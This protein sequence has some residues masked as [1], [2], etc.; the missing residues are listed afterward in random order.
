MGKNGNGIIKVKLH[1]LEEERNR[2]KIVLKYFSKAKTR[3]SKKT[4][5][6]VSRQLTT[7][8]EK[9]Y[10][11]NSGVHILTAVQIEESLWKRARGI[12]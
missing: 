12:I 3:M 7:I 2:L 10:K 8:I 9:E 6:A 1:D 4:A 11:N 5:M